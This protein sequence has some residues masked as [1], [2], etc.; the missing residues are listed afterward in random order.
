MAT[1]STALARMEA[2]R[3]ST[4][5]SLR[6]TREELELAK[7]EGR[8]K[9][10]NFKA[11]EAMRSGIDTLEILGGGAIAG[12]IDGTGTYLTLGEDSEGGGIDVPIGAPVGLALV[13]G[14]IATGQRDARKVGEGML[15]YGVGDVVAQLVERSYNR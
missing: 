12:A 5:A 1:S 4:L 6:R 3:Q 7:K 8:Q 14:G 10:S 11:G 2:A 15:A 9:L 13:I